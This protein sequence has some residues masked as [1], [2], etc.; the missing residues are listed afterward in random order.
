MVCVQKLVCLDYKS[1]RFQMPMIFVALVA[2]FNNLLAFSSSTPLIFCF[3][4]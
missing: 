1:S 2:F 3:S 4:V